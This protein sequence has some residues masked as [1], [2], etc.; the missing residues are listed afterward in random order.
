MTPPPITHL[1]IDTS[2]SDECDNGGCDYCLVPM[3]AE[4][5]AYLLDY[6]DEV[7]RMHRADNA[8]Y[9]LECWDGSH[10]YVRSS[11]WLQELRDADGDLA[12]DVPR[13]QP[14]LLTADP[15]IDEGDFQRVECQS[16]Q[17]LSEDIWWT[18]CVKHTGIRIESAHVEKKTLLR[19]F[20]NLG[21]TRER[22]SRP[23]AKPVPT[24]AQRI[25]DVLYLDTVD[26][27]DVYNPDKEWDAD[28]LSAIAEVVADFI[29]RP[30][31][32]KALADRED[33]KRG[34]RPSSGRP[35]LR[36]VTE[37]QTRDKSR[38]P[39]L[40]LLIYNAYP[41]SDL[42]PIDPDS[43][44]RNLKTLLH[45]VRDDD[46]G[47]SLFEFLV[48]EIVEGGQSTLKGGLRVLMRARDDVEAVLQAIMDASGTTDPSG[49]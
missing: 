6:M 45:R 4:Y 2:S 33:P 25:H 26:D 27:R 39:N 7:R 31:Q 38:R 32:I 42:L 11:D 30:V 17:V 20:R 8:I 16:V 23:K 10:L 41:H 19:I 21:R 46:I 24:V 15:K 35:G 48:V 37:G 18:A 1:M 13:G 12:A 3:T 22:T 28:I 40:A 34:S 29:P 5:I 36:N 14:I 43:D 47:D 9:S 44:C 49:E